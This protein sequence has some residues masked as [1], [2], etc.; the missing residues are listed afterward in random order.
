MNVGNLIMKA[1]AAES[2]ITENNICFNSHFGYEVLQGDKRLT[3]PLIRK[4]HT[5]QKC[6]WGEAFKLI[7][8][9]LPGLGINSAIFSNGNFTNEELHLINQIAEKYQIQ[10]KYSWELNGSI[11]QKKLGINYSPN[12]TSDLLSTDLI[13]LIGDV[14]HTLGIKIVQAVRAGKK[15]L[16]ISPDESKFSRIADYYIKSD[17]YLEIFNQFAKYFLEY[18]YHN[19]SYIANC[20]ENFVEYNH[21]LQKLV[22]NTE[23]YKFAEVIA[24]AGKTI[25]VYS[26]SFLDFNTQSSILNLSMLKGGV[27]EEGSGIIT[28]SELANKPTLQHYG[29]IPPIP[30]LSDKINSALIFGEDPLYN[31]K[32]ETY[33]WLNGLDF[34]LVADNYLTETAKMANVVLPLS[35]FVETNGTLVNNNNVFQ[36]VNKVISP[37][38]AKENWQ[39]FTKIL[40]YQTNFEN[41]VHE[42]NRDN[43]NAVNKESRFAI[44]KFGRKV[45]LQFEDKKA[46]S[47]ATINYNICR[48]KIDELK[49]AKVK[50]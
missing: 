22:H 49:K 24:K 6:S 40:D 29:F 26:E 32:L 28:C 34:L 9:K 30:Q 7:A 46:V 2:T 16:V 14:P 44:A 3:T 13:V 4:E 17:N 36:P 35:T 25:F 43:S 39:I 5:L 33:N 23:H 42:A 15:L 41:L 18:R 8:E 19:V 12:P 48:R 11:V 27:G 20:V 21:L 1:E 10:K 45:S 38:G 37:P 50:V 31:N 47:K